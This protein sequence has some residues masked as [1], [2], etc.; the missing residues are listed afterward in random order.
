MS[1]IKFKHSLSYYLKLFDTR[2]A[3]NDLLGALDAGRNAF[4]YART[5]IDKDSINLLLGQVYYDMELYTLSCDYYFRAIEVGYCRAGA[6]FGVGR[7]LVRLERYL[8]A[9]DY[10]DKVL[11]WDV[12]N[13]FTQSVLEWT[14]YIK[15]QI[16]YKEKNNIKDDLTKNIKKCIKHNNY[17]NAFQLINEMVQNNGDKTVAS[18]YEIECYVAMQDFDRARQLCKLLLTEQPDNADARLLMCAICKYDGDETSLLT[19]LGYIK[20]ENLSDMQLLSFAQL[21]ASV[22]KYDFAIDILKK[23]LK[24]KPY[25][26]R[27]NLYIAICYNN[28][29]DKEN[30]LYYLA[31]AR[32]IDYE[33]PILLDFHKIFETENVVLPLTE[34]LSNERYQQ[35]LTVIQNNLLNNNFAQR[36]IHSPLLMEQTDWLL[37][38]GNCD[39]LKLMAKTFCNS[40]HKCIKN[41]YKH[42]LLSVRP[43]MQQKFIL[44]REAVVGGF[45]KVV[46]LNA[47]LVYRSFYSKLPKFCYVNDS[48]KNSVINAW[49]YVECYANKTDIFANAKQLYRRLIMQEKNEIIEENVLTC[50]MFYNDFKIFDRV[51]KYFDVD[52]AAVENAKNILNLV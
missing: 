45:L 15:Q 5:R 1:I 13:L 33:N 50:L 6:Y 4:K 46:N 37:C 2:K 51:C 40:K 29:C 49:I 28:V 14:D 25:S 12:D 32:W 42:A 48:F 30:A 44:A 22:H 3:N 10:F 47:N 19:H 26:S 41:Y 36:W 34:K 39:V 35:K 43:S 27:V 21:Y 31:Q 11:E 16:N 7:N 52:I 9:L 17:V 38:S 20:Q 18:L 24:N 23:I 8:S